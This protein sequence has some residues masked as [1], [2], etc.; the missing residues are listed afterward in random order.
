M[1]VPC[2]LMNKE[3][4]TT[5]ARLIVRIFR[6]MPGRIGGSYVGQRRSL[7]EPSPVEFCYHHIA[8]SHAHTASPVAASRDTGSSSRGV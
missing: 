3:F 8:C 6:D 4:S 5:S 7:N 1:I 2:N